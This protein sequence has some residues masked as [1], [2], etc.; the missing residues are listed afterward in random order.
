AYAGMT[1]S[2]GLPVLDREAGAAAAGGGDVRIVELELRADQVVD[3][4]EFGA[5]HE[6]ERDRIDHD[7]RAVALDQEIVGRPLAH[8]VEAVLKPG[9]AAALDAYAKQRRRRLA[10]KQLGDAACRALADGDG[11]FAHL[12]CSHLSLKHRVAKALVNR[13]QTQGR[14]QVSGI[15]DG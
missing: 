11:R 4:I 3:E 2:G 15:R 13:P 8:E 1:R 9:A 5:L 6:A 7:A 10:P 14:T 12:G